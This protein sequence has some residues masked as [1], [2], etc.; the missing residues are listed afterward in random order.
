VH[1]D[2]V[3]H[4]ECIRSKDRNEA[5]K[6]AKRSPVPL[7]DRDD[8]SRVQETAAGNQMLRAA[9]TERQKN[10]KAAGRTRV[11]SGHQ[12]KRDSPGRGPRTSA[13]RIEA[14]GGELIGPSG[15]NTVQAEKQNHR[16]TLSRDH[17][18]SQEN[19]EQGWETPS[20]TMRELWRETERMGEN[21]RTA[22]IR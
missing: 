14:D 10:T 20:G 6:I 21:L 4:E 13:G 17:N 1:F 9:E 12:G 18:R 19:R 2:K 3:Y 22:R 16:R 11:S 15:Q 8:K 5:G 7:E